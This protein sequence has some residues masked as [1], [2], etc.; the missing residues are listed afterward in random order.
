M[1]WTKA[2]TMACGLAGLMGAAALAATPEQ[3]ISQRRAGYKHMGEN[4]KAM[5]DAIDGGAN[6]KPLIKIIIGSV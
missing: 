5:K 3:I 1:R 2:A 4:F 6:I